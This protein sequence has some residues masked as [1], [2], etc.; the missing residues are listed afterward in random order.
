MY[1]LVMRFLP[2]DKR[3]L[4]E[5]AL[6]MTTALDSAEKRMSVAMYVKEALTDG[7][8]TV[9]EWSRMGSKLGIL[10]GRFKPIK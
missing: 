6:A 9:G 2:A 1:K 4:L 7:K 8:I 10:R 3:A 5:L